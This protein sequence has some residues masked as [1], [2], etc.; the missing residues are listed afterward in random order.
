MNLRWRIDLKSFA[1][2][3]DVGFRFQCPGCLLLQE[4]YCEGTVALLSYKTESIRSVELIKNESTY[5]KAKAESCQHVSNIFHN[6]KILGKH[7]CC[8]RH[9]QRLHCLLKAVSIISFF[10]AGLL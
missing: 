5:S 4:V 7:I 10:Q 6:T 8:A 2:M 1:G 9:A 3:L